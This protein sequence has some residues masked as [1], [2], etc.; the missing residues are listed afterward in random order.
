MS[1][2]NFLEYFVSVFM[3]MA[4]TDRIMA[5]PLQRSLVNCLLMFAEVGISLKDVLNSILESIP[6]TIPIYDKKPGRSFSLC[7]IYFKLLFKPN[8]LIPNFNFDIIQ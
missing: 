2:G 8:S 1:F 6:D 4:P 5:E 3:Q 7:L